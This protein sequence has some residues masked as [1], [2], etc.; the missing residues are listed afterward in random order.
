[1]PYRTLGRTGE[2]VS[3]IGLGGWHLSRGSVS[4]QLARRLV[5][6]A[7]DRGINFMDNSWD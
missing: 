4:D 1:M 7:I 3:A 2:K 6:S 5:R